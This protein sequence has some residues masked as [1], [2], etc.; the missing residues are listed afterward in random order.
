MRIRHQF[1]STLLV[2]GF[3]CGSGGA[4]GPTG[5]EGTARW[6]PTR[7]ICRVDQPCTKP[8]KGTF[9][10][11]RD[12]QVVAQFESDSA[13]R[14]VVRLPPG[15]YTIGPGRNVGI[16]MRRQLHEVTVG[17]KGLTPVEL[18]FD[19]GISGIR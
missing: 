5:I 11:R 2:F 15:R 1:A 18:E 17:P 13:G 8:Y 3:G 4:S 9:D 7:P 12:T 16:I 14:F 19:T 6:G 10:V